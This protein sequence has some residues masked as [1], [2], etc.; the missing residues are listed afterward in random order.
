MRT[1]AM[2][3]PPGRSASVTLQLLALASWPLPPVR[4]SP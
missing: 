2:V 4:L 3:P 1:P